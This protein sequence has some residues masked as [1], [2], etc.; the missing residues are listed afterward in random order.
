MGWSLDTSIHCIS[1]E[2]LSRF[3]TIILLDNQTN[4]NSIYVIMWHK[5][6]AKRFVYNKLFYMRLVEEWKW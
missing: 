4:I 6:R 3:M 1:S 2:E 5:C